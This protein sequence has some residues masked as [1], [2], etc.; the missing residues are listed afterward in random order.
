[1]NSV[2]RLIEKGLRG[3]AFFLAVLSALSLVTI[4]IV[5]V[6]SVVLRKF[7]DT[8]LFF[9]EELVG[10]LMSAGLFLALPMA[11]INGQHIR[12]T[13]LLDAIKTKAPRAF[14]LVTL[15]GLLVGIGFTGWI[16]YEA[17]PWMDFAIRRGL[18]SETARILLYPLMSVVP[19]SMGLCCIIYCA[20]LFGIFKIK[21]R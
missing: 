15:C 14:K 9:T 16:L 6:T 2:S 7:F 4:L 20:K 13:L 18:K 1:M 21:A 19:I 17:L 3:S 5:I 11:T 8:P 12:I 10:L